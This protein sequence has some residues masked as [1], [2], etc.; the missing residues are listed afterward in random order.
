MST[1]LQRLKKR[2]RFNRYVQQHKTKKA[3]AEAHKARGQRKRLAQLRRKKRQQERLS[4]LKRLH[5]GYAVEQAKEA[6][7]FKNAAP[8]PFRYE[9]QKARAALAKAGARID[10]YGRPEQPAF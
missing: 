7:A 8:H 9:E 1:K 6:I 10:Q 4:G 5:N 3:K 2:Q